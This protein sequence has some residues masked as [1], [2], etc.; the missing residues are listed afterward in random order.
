MNSGTTFNTIRPEHT[1]REDVADKWAGRLGANFI[2]KKYWYA[3]P[4][5]IP[6]F[7]IYKYMRRKQWI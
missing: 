1:E 2:C 4:I 6:S 3:L 5:L 7:K